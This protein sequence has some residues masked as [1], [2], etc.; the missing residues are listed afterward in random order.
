MVLHLL[1]QANI[2]SSGK[3]FNL[4]AVNLAPYTWICPAAPCS[5]ASTSPIN[6]PVHC[7]H[8]KICL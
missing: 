1:T 5:Q 6:T 3:D 4:A 7:K 2:S 8:E